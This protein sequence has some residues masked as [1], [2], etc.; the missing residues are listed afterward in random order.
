MQ[1]FS[2]AVLLAC[3][4]IDRRRS[5]FCMIALRIK[6][7][8]PSTILQPFKTTKIPFKTYNYIFKLLNLINIIIIMFQYSTCCYC[9]LLLVFT[10]LDNSFPKWPSK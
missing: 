4:S 6:N 8:L 3:K 10:M 5:T 2:F 1:S 7:V 9:A